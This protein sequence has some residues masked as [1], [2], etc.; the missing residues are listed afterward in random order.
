MVLKF[1]SFEVYKSASYMYLTL[2]TEFFNRSMFVST[3]RYGLAA[4]TYHL[5]QDMIYRYIM[6][7]IASYPGLRGEGKRRPGAHCLRMHV[8]REAIVT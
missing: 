7:L 8:I 6:Y 2:A 1:G 3:Y 4:M 5:C